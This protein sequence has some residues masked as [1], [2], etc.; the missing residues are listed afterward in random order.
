MT[1]LHDASVKMHHALKVILETPH[2]RFHV[3]A[4]DPK[5]YEQIEDAVG[6]FEGFSEEAKSGLL[7]HG[8]LC[9]D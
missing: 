3:A 1:T 8:G 9:S 7:R 2:L 4:V 5:A 6:I